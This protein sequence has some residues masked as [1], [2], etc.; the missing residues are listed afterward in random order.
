MPIPSGIGITRF[1]TATLPLS[2]YRASTPGYRRY[3]CEIEDENP[4]R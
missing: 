4:S 3:G 1:R 2:G